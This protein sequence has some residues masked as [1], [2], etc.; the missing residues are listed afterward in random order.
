M[1]CEICGHLI[2]LKKYKTWTDAKTHYLH[3]TCFN[4]FSHGKPARRTINTAIEDRAD[5][6]LRK[7]NR[8]KQ[9]ATRATNNKIIQ[10]RPN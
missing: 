1:K 5:N 4:R 2:R 9:T 8:K 6:R 10:G 7:P 3:I